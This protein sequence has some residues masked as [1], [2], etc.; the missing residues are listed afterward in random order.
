MIGED[1]WFAS[2]DY[3]DELANRNESIS[4]AKRGAHP[5]PESR[6]GVAA[7]GGDPR[8]TADWPLAIRRST[9]L[10][11][12][13]KYELAIAIQKFTTPYIHMLKIAHFQ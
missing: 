4:M 2:R 11:R 7:M 6:P 5:R 12:V 3:T 1:T 10:W 9:H 13:A 8:P